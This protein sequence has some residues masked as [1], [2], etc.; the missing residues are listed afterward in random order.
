MKDLVKLLLI[1]IAGCI[2]VGLIFLFVVYG[3]RWED[4]VVNEEGTYGLAVMELEAF[5]DVIADT[6]KC[7]YHLYSPVCGFD[8]NT[9]DN[10]CLAVRAGTRVS[11]KGQCG[12]R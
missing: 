11:H 9:Y 3:G 7:D 5:D 12:P 6:G 10:A 1:P 8:G 4:D 2:A